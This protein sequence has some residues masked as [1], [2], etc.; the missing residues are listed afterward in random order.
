VSEIEMKNFTYILF[1]LII[2]LTGCGGGVTDSTP[3][4]KSTPSIIDAT[5]SLGNLEGAQINFTVSGGIAGVSD[6]WSVYGDGRF[7][8]TD[9]STHSADT[10]QL[11]ILLKTMD[12]IDLFELDYTPDP[13]SSCAD[14][15]TYRL[16]VS[17]TGRYKELTWRDGDPELP[18]VLH[19]VQEL[20]RTFFILDPPLLDQ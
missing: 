11:S 18:V 9:G 14:C 20:V 16:T 1:L 10:N 6:S 8:A 3:L 5:S 4:S 13:F 15:F 2:F 7:L 19:E 17:Y 12:Q